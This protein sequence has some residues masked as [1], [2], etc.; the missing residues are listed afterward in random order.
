MN[1]IIWDDL[2]DNKCEEIYCEKIYTFMA[3]S[4]RFVSI[5]NVIQNCDN[6][7]NCSDEPFFE[8]AQSYRLNTNSSGLD[9]GLD[10]YIVNGASFVAPKYDFYG[11]DRPVGLIDA[12]AVQTSGVTSDIEGVFVPPGEQFR[13]YPNPFT[14]Y[15]I[16]GM[17]NTSAVRSVTLYN[18][19][20]QL[21]QRIDNPGEEQL[22]IRRGALPPGMYFLRI[23]AD[24]VYTRKVIAE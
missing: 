6:P 1:N 4:G 20:G 12:G 9:I 18:M 23:E 10:A 15:F 7:N 3:N 24:K 14:D 17:G 19:S 5:K 2:P 16:V 13:I 11:V 22:I 8:D 21:Q